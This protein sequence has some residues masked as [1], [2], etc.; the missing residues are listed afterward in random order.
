MDVRVGFQDDKISYTTIGSDTLSS[1]N[2]ILVVGNA[3]D[4]AFAHLSQYSEIYV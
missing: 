2:F 4:N 3:Q 1:C